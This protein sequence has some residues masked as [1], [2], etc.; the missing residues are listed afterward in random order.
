LI[1]IN[2][3]TYDQLRSL[4]LSTTQSRRLLA[5][6]RRVEGFKSLN[7]LDAIPGFPSAVLDQLKQRLST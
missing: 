1:D 6:R 2:D 7:E 4:K 3:A 5:Y